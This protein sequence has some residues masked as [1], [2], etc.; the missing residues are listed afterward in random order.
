M[1][2]ANKSIT[3]TPAQV[4]I[5]K[6][7]KGKITDRELA[8]KIDVPFGKLKNQV[9]YLGL[10]KSRVKHPVSFCKTMFTWDWAKNVEPLMCNPERI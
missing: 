4:E 7:W 2:Q 1:R 8:A 3:L 9:R 10:V 5:V 6:E